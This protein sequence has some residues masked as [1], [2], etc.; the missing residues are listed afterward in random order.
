MANWISWTNDKPEKV[1]VFLCWSRSMCYIKSLFHFI[2]MRRSK[3]VRQTEKKKKILL[4]SEALA[5]PLA[6][7]SLHKTTWLT[8]Y[9]VKVVGCGSYATMERWC[10]MDG[11]TALP[12]K[13]ERCEKTLHT[14]SWVP[15][16]TSVNN[17]F[18]RSSGSYRLHT[19]RGQ[20]LS[21]LPQLCFT[22][23]RPVMIEPRGVFSQY[24]M[25]VRIC[26]IKRSEHLWNIQKYGSFIVLHREMQIG[27][28][29]AC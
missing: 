4:V 25:A 1:K 18:L 17:S 5:V 15:S 2:E 21:V 20:I 6:A 26:F 22:G 13:A 27:K 14:A 7:I 23:I 8:I 9:N 16:T 11:N 10:M 29:S 24:I 28:I 3:Q 19:I 12:T